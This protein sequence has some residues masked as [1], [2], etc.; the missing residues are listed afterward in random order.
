MSFLKR[1][2]S[3]FQS[4]RALVIPAENYNVSGDHYP[5]GK[6]FT[7]DLIRNVGVTD[8]INQLLASEQK[9]RQID[10][11]SLEFL[12]LNEEEIALIVSKDLLLSSSVHDVL[13]ISECLVSNKR[14]KM[15]KGEWSFKDGNDNLTAL[16]EATRVHFQAHRNLRQKFSEAYRTLIPKGPASYSAKSIQ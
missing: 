3:E 4:H 6:S 2:P 1:R 16:E 12:G 11:S 14:L 13:T 10:R 5:V 7:C 9:G 8:E 15:L